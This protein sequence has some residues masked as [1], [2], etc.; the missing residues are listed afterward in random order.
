[1]R[2]GAASRVLEGSRAV[3]L[4]SAFHAVSGGH[5]YRQHVF[6][7]EDWTILNGPGVDAYGKSKTLA[8]HSA[9]E[10]IAAEMADVRL[11]AV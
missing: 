2:K 7:E 4:T 3:V 6:T 9:W 10:F 8:E 1:M 11:G 5:P